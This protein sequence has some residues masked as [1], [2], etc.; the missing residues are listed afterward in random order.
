MLGRR[1]VMAGDGQRAGLGARH[2][3]APVPGGI[4][5]MQLE[6][7]G[8]EF[9]ELGLGHGELAHVVLLQLRGIEELAL[10]GRV[11]VDRQQADQRQVDPAID[12]FDRVVGRDFAA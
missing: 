10:A 8:V 1:I 3:L 2:D 4:A 5:L 9:L 6:S 11:V 12:C 7:P